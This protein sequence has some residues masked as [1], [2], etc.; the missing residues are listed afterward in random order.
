VLGHLDVVFV[1]A[2]LKN[3]NTVSRREDVD[4]AEIAAK[5]RIEHRRFAG[6]DLADND[7]KEWLIKVRGEVLQ[8]TQ[9]IVGRADLL[10]KDE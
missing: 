2:I 10:C 3:V 7:K 6:F 5:K 1:F 4:L 8:I 9:R